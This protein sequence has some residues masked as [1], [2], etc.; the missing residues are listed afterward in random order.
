MSAIQQIRPRLQAAALLCLVLVHAGCELSSSDEDPVNL[1]T[2]IVANQG[3]F[4]DGNGSLTSYDPA[5][6]QATMMA[7]GLASIVQSVE[8]IGDRIYVASNTGNRIDVFAAADGQQVSQ[9][10]DVSSPRYIARWTSSR[11]VV[12]NLFDNTLSIVDIEGGEII[13]TIAVGANPE[14]V[15]V[16]GSEAFVANHA[17]GGGNSLSVVNL[18]TENVARTIEVD[19]D[20]PRFVFVDA[21]QD[22]LVVCTGQVLFDSEFNVIGETDGA[23]LFLDPETGSEK[24]RIAVEGMI[25]TAGPGQDAFYSST[26]RRLF[27]VRDQESILVIDTDLDAVI[28]TIG[29]FE[30]PAIGGVAFHGR[31][32]L[33]YVARVPGFTQAGR[34]TM[35]SLEN[36]VVGEFVAGV[37][38]SHV[39]FVEP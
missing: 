15:L 4:S 34:V 24:G 17:F 8:V 3:N 13:A 30:G 37:A 21:Q 22:L 31:E 26:L 32:G 27:V 28:D 11:I 35:I 20:G 6:R 7:S 18:N 38:P 36:R 23:V 5:A 1:G 14:G 29:P 33:L 25:T 19:C 10:T 12:T 2:V 9:I 16:R 39:A